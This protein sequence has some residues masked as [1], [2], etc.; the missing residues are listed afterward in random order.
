[1]L[2]QNYRSTQTILQAANKVIEKN[3]YRKKKNLFTKN[4]EGEKIKIYT[5]YDETDEANFIANAVREMLDKGE[6]GADG[7]KKQIKPDDIAVLYR[8]NFQSRAIEDSFLRKNI[9][10]TLLGTKFFE[11]K[12]VKDVISYIRLALNPDSMVDVK[13]VINSPVRGIGKTT[14]LKVLEGKEDELINIWIEKIC[15]K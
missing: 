9:A 13:R 15:R 7:I 11:R 3:I 4:E 1:M 2:E 14:L 5:A 6:V 8:A 12:E 10:Y